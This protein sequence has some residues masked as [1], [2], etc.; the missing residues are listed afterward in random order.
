M[1]KKFMKVVLPM[2][3]AATM[4]FSVT[5]CNSKKDLETWVKSDEAV[6]YVDEIN[7]S[8]AGSGMS[9]SFEAEGDTLSFIYTF[10]QIVELPKETM[11]QTFDA[12]SSEF[13]SAREELVK[14]T[15]NKD[16][17]IRFVYINGDGS[18][19]YSKEI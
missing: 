5:G 8:L 18:E 15:G 6:E 12:M 1:K 19:L 3:V 10:D 9:V 14:Y 11:D 7:S 16:L 13:D 4:M 17:K 2:L